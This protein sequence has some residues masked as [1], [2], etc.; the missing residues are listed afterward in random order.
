[1]HWR[2]DAKQVLVLIGDAEAHP[3]NQNETFWRVRNFVQG[4]KL[5][6]FSALFVTTPSSLSAGNIARSDFQAIAKAGNG[7]FNDHTGSMMESVLLS[8][9]VK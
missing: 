6:S 8:V 5:R 3:E 7:T 9:L 4:N 1:M 2:P